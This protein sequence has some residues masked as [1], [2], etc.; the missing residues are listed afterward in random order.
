MEYKILINNEEL[1]EYTIIPLNEQT[2]LDESLDQGYLRLNYTNKDGA[3]RPFTSVDIDITD[4]FGNTRELNYFIASDN[5]TEIIANGTYNHELLLIEQSKWLERFLTGTKT[6]THP[7]IHDYWALQKDLLVTRKNTESGNDYYYYYTDSRYKQI[8]DNEEIF[9]IPSANTFITNFPYDTYNF[10]LTI[11]KNGVKVLESSSTSDTYDTTL[12]EQASYEVEYYFRRTGGGSSVQE[13][14]Y[15]Y[16]IQT[17]GETQTKPNKTITDA[18]NELLATIETLRE[19]E[20]PRF[21][22]NSEQATKYAQVDAPEF[23]LTGTLWEALKLIGSYIHAIP[24]LKNNTIYFDE[25]GSNEKI[26]QNLSDYVSNTERFDI[27]QYASAIDSTVQNIVNLDDIE[28]GS[29]TEPFASG[30]KTPRTDTAVVQITDGNL[31]IQTK[32]PIEQIIKVEMGYLS[33]GTYVGDITPYVYESAEY[34]TLSSYEDNYPYAKAYAIKYTIGQKNITELNFKRESALSTDVFERYAIIN[35]ASRVTG[36]SYSVIKQLIDAENI[37]KLQFSVTYIPITDA[38]VKQRKQLKNNNEFESVLPY[39]Q[40]A[41][42]ISSRAYG[43]AMKGAIARLGNPEV[44]KVYILNDLSKIPRIGQ[45]FDDNY[46]ISVIKCEYFKDFVRCELGLSKNFNKLNEYV[47]IKSEVRFYEISEKQSTD[48][49]INYEEYCIVGNEE[50]SDTNSLITDAGVEQFS[51]AFTGGGSYHQTN[52]VL[53]KA[54]YNTAVILPVTSYGMGNSLVF[55]F[56]YDDNYSAGETVSRVSGSTL[57]NQIRY[58]DVYGEIETLE[59]NYGAYYNYPDDYQDAIE[60]GDSYPLTTQLE[61]NS[62]IFFS[63]N[64]DGIRI[65]KDNRETPKLTYQ[66]HFV[67]NKDGV[68]IG[69]GLARYSTLVTEQELD[70][71][72]YVLQEEIPKF[73]KKIGLEQAIEVNSSINPTTD[74]Y[75]VRL[76][77]F[78]SNANGKA[79]AICQGDELIVGENMDIENGQEVQLPTFTFTRGLNLVANF[80]ANGGNFNGVERKIVNQE[81]G[82]TYVFP[83]TPTKEYCTFMGWYLEQYDDGVT[84]DNTKKIDETTVVLDNISRKIYAYWIDNRSIHSVEYHKT[85][86]YSLTDNTTNEF[87]DFSGLKPTEKI[88]ING[89]LRNVNEKFWNVTVYWEANDTTY[90]QTFDI[91]G[92]DE[93]DGISLL[94]NGFGV[95]INY[96]GTGL[97]LGEL[98]GKEDMIVDCPRNDVI[99]VTLR[100]H[101]YSG[102]FT[103]IKFNTV[104]QYE[105]Y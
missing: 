61:G 39:N 86:T 8:V 95:A 74:D 94:G 101:T 60:K 16:Q 13:M 62:R 103:G 69:S 20:T 100:N 92:E 6:V 44:T 89:V 58:T 105:Y 17:I 15:S 87:T 10:R 93:V 91:Q 49:Y 30:F 63:T 83:E 77:S 25:L 36:K 18:V 50:E 33:D 29:I 31:F 72:I 78:I 45:L 28:E 9:T 32:E 24:R 3:Y 99:T 81:Q 22:F 80:D 52:A 40:S 7:L 68:I 53:A 73:T 79:W 84:P 70:Y 71:K 85:G 4:D 35:I 96:N 51:E 38:R 47:G 88:K 43:E 75:K 34:D 56:H 5:K 11:W 55:T 104:T 90:S 64:G 1:T 12:K 54:D 82:Q 76:G 21:V 2:T 19:S 46:Y 26:S 66:I 41:Q 48:R 57:Q 102:N 23:T 37:L 98:G 42:K 67:T 97:F 14:T 27:E 65:K 59:L